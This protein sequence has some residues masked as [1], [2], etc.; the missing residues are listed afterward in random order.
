MIK[1][2]RE[3]GAMLHSRELRQMGTVLGMTRPSLKR[4]FERIGNVHVNISAFAAALEDVCAGAVGYGYAVYDGANPHPIRSGKHGYALLQPYMPTPFTPAT[5]LNVH[6]ISKTVTSAVM[7]RAMHLNNKVKLGDEIGPYLRPRWNIPAS[8]AFR[9]ITFEELLTHNSGLV[10][11]EGSIDERSLTG[12]RQALQST[13]N[14]QRGARTYQNVNLSLCRILLPHIDI[15]SP[16]SK[17]AMDAMDEETFNR[18]TLEYFIGYVKQHF[19]DP[20]GVPPDIRPRP[21]PVGAGPF[22]RYYNFLRPVDSIA[23]AE[24]DSLEELVGASAWFM[25]ATEYGKFIMGVRYQAIF[26]EQGERWSPWETMVAYDRRKK[27]SSTNAAVY[28]L[29]M[30]EEDVG[31]AKGVVGLGKAGGGSS[32]YGPTSGWIAFNNLTAVVLINSKGGKITSHLESG[33]D[34]PDLT[35]LTALR[36][37]VRAALTGV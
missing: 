2:M 26:G 16:L 4:V 31:M 22:T 10:D 11:I 35:G 37:A 32:I 30:T 3:A 12:M 14:Q 7:I 28:R 15:H 17:S 29:G 1:T 36:L 13:N 6:S 8:S 18:K 23:D 34:E 9:K 5:R 20:L 21:N 19:F 33:E 24:D 25:S 27:S